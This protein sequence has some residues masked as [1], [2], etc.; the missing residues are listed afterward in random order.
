MAKEQI[1][2]QPESIEV[3]IDDKKV[4]KLQKLVDTKES[5]LSK[6]V[7][8][9]SMDKTALG[10]YADVIDGINW[11][12]KESLGIVEISKKID[13][14]TKKG[15][16]DDVIFMSSLEIEASHYF[17]NKFEGKGRSLALG[18]I[19][20]FKSFEQ[21]LSNISQDNKD[22]ADLKKELAGAQQGL[23]FE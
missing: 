22:L 17:L 1:L 4:K 18:F 9:V 12:G 2:D 6:K 8:A 16:T 23:S 19:N 14:I 15:I 11:R 7:Y 10:L 20:L 13:D 3:T 5:E 21:A